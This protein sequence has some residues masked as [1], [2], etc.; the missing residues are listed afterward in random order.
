[1]EYAKARPQTMHS[2]HTQR[3]ARWSFPVLD[4]P[5]K[6]LLYPEVATAREVYPFDSIRVGRHILLSIFVPSP[7][8]YYN[9][10]WPQSKSAD[11]HVY[12]DR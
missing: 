6:G 2:Q 5:K 4:S 8:D 12:C 3:R 9:L 11:R 1:M 10:L 7:I